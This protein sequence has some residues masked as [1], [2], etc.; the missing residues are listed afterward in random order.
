VGQFEKN[1]NAAAAALVYIAG[2]FDVAICAQAEMP[3]PLSN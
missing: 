3:V 1:K 2:I